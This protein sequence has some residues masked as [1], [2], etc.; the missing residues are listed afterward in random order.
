[1][2]RTRG[3]T[4]GPVQAL[5]SVQDPTGRIRT[6]NPNTITARQWKCFLPVQCWC[7]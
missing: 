5:P 2:T 4:E 7:K 6:K 3:A 1:M